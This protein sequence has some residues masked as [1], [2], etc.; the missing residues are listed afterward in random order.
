MLNTGNTL[1]FINRIDESN[2]GDRIVS[3]INFYW[4]FFKK[5]NLK[6]HD[7]RFIDYASI[8]PTDV[9]ILGGGGLLNY[10]ECLNRAI[11]RLLDTKSTVIAWAPGFNTHSEYDGTFST[12]IDFKRFCMVAVRDFSNSYGLEYLP[13]VT[14]KLPTL[15]E[16]YA[17]RRKYGVVSHK[18]YP[19]NSVNMFST[20][21]NSSPVEDIIRFIGESEIVL[22]N[23]FHVIYWA[24][25]MGK[26]TV[27]VDPMSSRLFSYKYKPA[28]YYSDGGNLSESV[29]DAQQYNIIDECIKANDSFFESVK[30]IIEK[31]LVPSKD[32]EANIDL[33]T[34]SALMNQQYRETRY[35]TGDALT[36]Q[37]YIDIGNGY[38]EECKRVA[39]NNVL[40]DEISTVRFDISAYSEIKELRFDPVEGQ[41]CKVEIISAHD[42]DGEVKPI[43]RF[44]VHKENIDFFLTTDPQFFIKKPCR[45]FVEIKFKLTLLS[46]FEAEQNVRNFVEYQEHCFREIEQSVNEKK[47]CIERLEQTL[48][49]NGA[50]I[51]HQEKKIS[52][53]LQK[54]AERENDMAVQVEKIAGLSQ[55]CCE[56]ENDIARK[57][58]KITELIGQCSKRDEEIV[59]QTQTISRQCEHID[60]LEKQRKKLNS[61]VNVQELVINSQKEEMNKQAQLLLQTKNELEA[62]YSSQSWKITAPLRTIIDFFKRLLKGNKK[63]EIE[64]EP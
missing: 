23:S 58:E 34:T 29:A 28:Y 19:L 57:N 1:H 17:L 18:D 53:L 7:I 39:I 43:S 40:G 54:C 61:T 50:I 51:S 63:H 62:L 26:K 27:C 42:A 52:E 37:L 9:V 3:P 32:K 55:K 24:L 6:R 13:D 56:Q 11:N 22:S 2:C 64:Q 30:E 60:F 15:K 38:N 47:V 10:S 21:T 14:C 33:I 5:Y 12:E 16:K 49:D 59:L 35:M 45:L 36:S 20:I 46:R 41:Y 8:A 48:S 31:R 44:S 4:D 25:L